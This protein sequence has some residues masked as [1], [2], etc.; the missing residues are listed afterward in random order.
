[1]GG[2]SNGTDCYGLGW[3]AFLS[4]TRGNTGMKCVIFMLMTAALVAVVGCA[5]SP[6]LVAKINGAYHTRFDVA[7]PTD[8]TTVPGQR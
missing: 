8:T 1:L 3:A 6:D 5:D 4:K 2:V 7:S